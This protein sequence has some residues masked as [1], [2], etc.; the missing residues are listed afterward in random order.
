MLATPPYAAAPAG[1]PR[2]IAVLG[3]GAG[4]LAGA[5]A[6]TDTPELRVRHR[7][8]VYPGGLGLG[9][10]GEIDVGFW[11]S[12][13]LVRGLGPLRFVEGVGF[14]TP[15]L[16]VDDGWALTAG[17]E[18]DEAVFSVET[19]VLDRCGPDERARP[20]RLV[21]VR[22]AGGG[23]RGPLANDWGDWGRARAEAL[24]RLRPGGRRV[25]LPGLGLARRRRRAC[26]AADRE[27]P[28]RRR[29]RAG[30]GAGGAGGALARA[31]LHARARQDAMAGVRRGAGPGP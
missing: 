29:A 9:R 16:F 28:A 30:R 3:G 13:A 31:R 15:Y 18:V 12:F 6:L 26:A 25:M 5:F 14:F 19:V 1:P 17:R 7:V 2:T 24:G 23:A 4:A 20:E 11:V 21:E 27:P 10:V 8:T 22:R